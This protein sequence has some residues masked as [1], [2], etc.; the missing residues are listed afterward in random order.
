MIS[1]NPYKIMSWNVQDYHSNIPTNWQILIKF[2]DGSCASHKSFAPFGRNDRGGSCS[3]KKKNAIREHRQKIFVRLS[4]FWPLRGCDC[5][6]EF[7]KKG[8]FETKIFFSDNDEWSSN[9]LW[10]IM[11]AD[12]KANIKQQEIKNLVAYLKNVYKSYL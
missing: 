4:G 1:P 2:W 6:S 11:S 7:V 12:V 10:K 3:E 9:N 8:K 5:L